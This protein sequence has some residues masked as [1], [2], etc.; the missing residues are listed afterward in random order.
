MLWWFLILACSAGAV[1]W[2]GVAMYLRVRHHM[3]LP[4]KGS[5]DRGH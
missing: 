5:K 3:K 2:A 1:L 4:D